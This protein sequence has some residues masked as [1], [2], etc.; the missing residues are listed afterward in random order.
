MKQAARDKLK[1]MNVA[2]SMK[3]QELGGSIVDKKKTA[4]QMAR[5]IQEEN[6]QAA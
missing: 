6:R 2:K 1:E 4:R 3:I 5:I